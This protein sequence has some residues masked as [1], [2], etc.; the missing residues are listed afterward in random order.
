MLALVLGLFVVTA[1]THQLTPF[2][3]LG[4]AAGL[5][6]VRR[7]V[8]RSLPAILMLVLLAWISYMTAP[9]WTGHLHE[10]VAGVGDLGGTFSSGVQERAAGDPDHQVV[11]LT[12]I[13][14]CLALFGT[15]AVGLWRRARRGVDDRILVVLLVVPVLAAGLQSY[16]GE[17]VL[18]VYLFALP[19]LCVLVALAVFPDARSRA[20]STR[21]LVAAGL[22]TMLLL[23]GFL[24]ARYGNE[25]YEQMRPQEYAAAEFV[26]QQPGPSM[27]LFPTETRA[28]AST[29]FLPISY[30]DIERVRVAPVT[31]TPDPEDIQSVITRMRDQATTPYLLVTRGQLDFLVISGGYPPGWGERF[32]AALDRAPELTVLGADPDA[33]LYA[34]RERP[35]VAAA[36]VAPLPPGFIGAT[37][38]TP[39]GLLFLSVLLVTLIGREAWRLRHPRSGLAGLWPLRILWAPLGIAFLAVVVERAIALTS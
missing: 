11:V 27:V 39:V 31:M 30:R 13:A 35:A 17:I 20:G 9:Y 33:R 28:A 6:L 7:C 1:A 22:C 19:A 3:M 26:D 14:L 2:V 16:G 15:A 10:L 32:T 8:A 37:P 25:A 21:R 23:G 12:R 5:V 24:L 36:P 29:P 38:W 4:V 34:L 18:R